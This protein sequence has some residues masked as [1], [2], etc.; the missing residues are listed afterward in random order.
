ML[1]EDNILKSSLLIHSFDLWGNRVV[2]GI[3][4]VATPPEFRRRGYGHKIVDGAITDL[5]NREDSS[6][7][8]L[9]SNIGADFY[10][11]HGFVTLPQRH[12]RLQE[13]LF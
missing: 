3:G 10:N 8:F 2:C 9:Y 12:T 7:I 4:S 11:Q 5:T 13:I 6:I 1:S